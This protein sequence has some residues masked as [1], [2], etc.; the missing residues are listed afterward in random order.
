MRLGSSSSP[1]S[2]VAVSRLRKRS[3]RSS[4]TV[5]PLLPFSPK[6]NEYPPGEADSGGGRLGTPRLRSRSTSLRTESFTLRFAGEVREL[7]RGV[8][9]AT[10]VYTSGGAAPAHQ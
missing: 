5:S 6:G 3:A 7:P 9:S 2:P 10:R 4:K 8:S 1:A